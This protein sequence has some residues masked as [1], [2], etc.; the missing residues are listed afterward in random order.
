MTEGS[1]SLMAD[2]SQS[3]SAFRAP[4]SMF[5]WGLV[6]APLFY[7]WFRLIN[8]LRVEW[9]T[10]PQYSYGYIVPFLC[11]GLIFQRWKSEKARSG[12][13]G[14]GA[15]GPRTTDQ[16]PPTTGAGSGE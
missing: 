16:R 14:A 5:W 11:V 3:D 6:V 8:N 10:N 13:Q 7:L 1:T 12:E 2:V 4:R 9:E 15:K